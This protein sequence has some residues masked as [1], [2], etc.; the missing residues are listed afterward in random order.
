MSEH[1]PRRPSLEVAENVLEL[2]NWRRLKVDPMLDKH[3]AILIDGH[4]GQPSILAHMDRTNNKLDYNNERLKD[5]VWL[6]KAI[7]AM[8]PLAVALI[9]LVEGCGPVWRQKLGLPITISVPA[10][11]KSSVQLPQ[12]PQEAVQPMP[13]VPHQQ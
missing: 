4:E 2:N 13:E 6:G 10:P 11:S 1:E 3:Q 12:K 8:I 7:A 5:L 9:G